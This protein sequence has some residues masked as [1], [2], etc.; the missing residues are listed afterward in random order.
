MPT[1]PTA[2]LAPVEQAAVSQTPIGGRTQCMDQLQKAKEAA[3]AARTYQE[4]ASSQL[5]ALSR[6]L[7]AST[8]RALA[9]AAQLRRPPRRPGTRPA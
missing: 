5:G 2:P 4:T 7:R 9:T 1:P 3:A 8:D 6:D